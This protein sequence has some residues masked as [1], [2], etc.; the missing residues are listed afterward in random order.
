MNKVS[1]L[2]FDGHNALWR[3]SIKY[4]KPITH[5]LCS[6]K[7]HTEKHMTDIH[8]ACGAPWDEINNIC[9]GNKYFLVYNFFKNLKPII[10]KFKPD[11]CFFVLEGFPQFRHDLYP[12]YKA[13]RFVKTA[14][15]NP[16]NQIKFESFHEQKNIV[17]D[18]LKY[19]PITVCKANDYEADDVISSLCEDMKNEQLTIVSNDS[20]F[21]QL[22]Q[23]GYDFIQIYN[24]IKKEF[25]IAP[26]YPYVAWKALNGDKSDN[27][28]SILTP[29]KALKTIN[30]PS[31]FKAFLNKNEENKYL[32]NVNKRLI[33]FA[34]VNLSNLVIYE[35]DINYDK[36][37]HLLNEMRFHSITN[38]T[39]WNKFIDV[40]NC[41]NI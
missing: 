21:I 15:S 23:R 26:E 30:N 19:L 3:A 28:K 25:M 39:S 29:A 41:L 40:F 13:N 24:P 4:G 2:I 22:L 16:S 17:I 11:K 32:F 38:E 31:L 5:E 14:S 6:V 9:F 1:V 35:N 20:D 34:H 37:K 18:L 27:I 8:C 36:L 7:Y 12:E 10:E 33:E